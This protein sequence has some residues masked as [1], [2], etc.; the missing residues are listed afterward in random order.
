MFFYPAGI[1]NMECNQLKNKSII[2]YSED[3][4]AKIVVKFK[5][6][7]SPVLFSTF[8]PGFI[9]YFISK[10]RFLNQIKENV[11]SGVQL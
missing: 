4:T 5:K 6:L 10:I 7:H 2:Y 9:Y 1:E 11:S 8:L 3:V